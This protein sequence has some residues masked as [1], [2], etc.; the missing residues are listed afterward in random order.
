VPVEYQGDGLKIGFNAR[1]LI[2]VLQ[3]LVV[4]TAAWWARRSR[5]AV[6]SFSSPPKTLGHSLKARLLVTRTDFRSY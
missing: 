3:A 6:V 5:S 1:Y 2:D 4:S